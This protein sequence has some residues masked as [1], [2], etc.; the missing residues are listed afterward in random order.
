MIT[1]TPVHQ[2]KTNDQYFS[3]STVLLLLWRAECKK[4]VYTISWP[5]NTLALWGFLKVHYPGM[6]VIVVPMGCFFGMLSTHILMPRVSWENMSISQKK[7]QRFFLWPEDSSGQ[8]A[9][10]TNPKRFGGYREYFLLRRYPLH[11]P[12]PHEYGHLNTNTS[13]LKDLESHIFHTPPLHQKKTNGRLKL[14]K[15]RYDI[16]IFHVF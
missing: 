1:E 11:S 3:P 15:F 13:P 5:E 16:D 10:F 7:N 6:H 14:V 9:E 2:K 8:T 12:P 4:H